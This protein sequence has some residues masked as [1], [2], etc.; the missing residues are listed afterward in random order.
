MGR[1]HGGGDDKA[2]K[3]VAINCIIAMIERV[4][5]WAWLLRFG[6]GTCDEMLNLLQKNHH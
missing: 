5:M 4:M 6:V 1:E 2:L 3:Q